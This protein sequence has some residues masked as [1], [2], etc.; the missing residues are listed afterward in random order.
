MHDGDWDGPFYF[1]VSSHICLG[2]HST[3][4]LCYSNNMHINNTFMVVKCAEMYLHCK[5][6]TR[7]PGQ[8]QQIIVTVIMSP[9]RIGWWW[10]RDIKSGANIK[11]KRTIKTDFWLCGMSWNVTCWHGLNQSS[12]IFC[13]IADI[14]CQHQWVIIS[15]QDSHVIT[16]IYPGHLTPLTG[17][18]DPS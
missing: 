7:A 14:L 2:S 4:Y 16:N 13:G 1:R 9:Q 12:G 10:A 6:D 11:T 17:N 18:E 8:L 3:C 15:L 5:P